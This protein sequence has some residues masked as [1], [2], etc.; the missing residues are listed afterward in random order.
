[1]LA[2]CSSDRARPEIL[3]ADPA[4]GSAD[5]QIVLYGNGF[6]LSTC[7]DEAITLTFGTDIPAIGASLLAVTAQSIQF[8]IP[9]DAPVGATELIVTVGDEA[10]DGFAFTVTR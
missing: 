6:C 10:S 3:S 1:M 2:A 7:A 5:D 8:V 4:T 9:D